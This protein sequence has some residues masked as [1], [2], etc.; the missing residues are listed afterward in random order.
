MS[1][2]V[3]K[4]QFSFAEFSVDMRIFPTHVHIRLTQRGQNRFRIIA[5]ASQPPSI[6]RWNRRMDCWTDRPGVIPDSVL[7]LAIRYSVPA[8]DYFEEWWSD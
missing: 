3:A 4:H 1:H 6:A 5:A 2:I 7:W 8:D